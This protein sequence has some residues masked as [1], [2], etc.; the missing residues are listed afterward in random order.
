[1]R[2]PYMIIGFFLKNYNLK[3]QTQNTNL[4]I[5]SQNPDLRSQYL[6]TESKTHNEFLDVKLNV[7]RSKNRLKQQII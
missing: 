4:I 7:K 6:I 5:K 1:M 3:S 2:K